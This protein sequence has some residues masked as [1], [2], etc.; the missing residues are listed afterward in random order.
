MKR[1]PSNSPAPYGLYFNLW[2]PDARFVGAAGEP[3]NEKATAVPL[4]ARMTVSFR[5]C[6]AVNSR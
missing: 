3:L 5:A 1:Y 2:P 6:E 4:R